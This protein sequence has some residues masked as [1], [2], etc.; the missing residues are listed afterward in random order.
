[1][2]S[3]CPSIHLSYERKGFGAFSDL[4]VSEYCHGFK[5]FSPELIVTQAESLK[6]DSSS[7]WTAIHNNVGQVLTSRS[8]M[9]NKIKETCSRY[10]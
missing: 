6:N 4:G 7:Y 5:K 9:L 3:G 2:I 1:M 8:M 10:K